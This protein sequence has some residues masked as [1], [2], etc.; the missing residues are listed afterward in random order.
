MQLREMAMASDQSHKPK[1]AAKVRPELIARLYESEASGRLDEDLLDRVGIALLLRVESTLHYGRN[2]VRCPAC[3]TVFVVRDDPVICPGPNCDWQ[4]TCAIYYSTRRHRDLNIANALP[5]FESFAS[6]YPSART[7]ADRMR[8]ID[9][10]IH[11]F[12]WDSKFGVPNRSVGNN[13]IEGR[14][15]DVVAFLDALSANGREESKEHWRDITERM[16]QR[17]G[18]SASPNPGQGTRIQ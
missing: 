1:W 9:R 2:Q 5:A 6:A 17:R 18:A 14:H 13:L 15:E 11:E 4:T 16:R 3:R 10:L 7:T 8:L 12:H